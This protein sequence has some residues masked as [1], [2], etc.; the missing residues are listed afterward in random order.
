MTSDKIHD[1]LNEQEELSDQLDEHMWSISEAEAQA[2]NE[3]ALCGDAWA[4][5]DQDIAWSCEVARKLARLL[6][7]NAR[8]LVSAGYSPAPLP[9]PPPVRC[10]DPGIPF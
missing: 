8:L 6:D 2:A 7:E 3:R 10:E 4:G 1:L 9:P 5:A